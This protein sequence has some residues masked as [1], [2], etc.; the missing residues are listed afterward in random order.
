MNLE[1]SFI[2]IPFLARLIQAEYEELQ[3]PGLRCLAS[4]C[5]TNR[6][7]SDIVCAT[8]FLGKPILDV[9]VALILR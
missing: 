3:L 2:G 5:F 7:V 9:L 1:I 4:M 8:N 6:A